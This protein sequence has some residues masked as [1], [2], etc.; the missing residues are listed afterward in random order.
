[1]V[2]TLK[3]ATCMQCHCNT[4]YMYII[5]TSCFSL[6]SFVSYVHCSVLC[7]TEDSISSEL[8]GTSH[9]VHHKRSFPLTTV[10]TCCVSYA[11]NR[12][13]YQQI[14]TTEEVCR[15]ENIMLLIMLFFHGTLCSIIV[16]LCFKFSFKNKQITV[17]GNGGQL[18]EEVEDNCWRKW[19][20]T[21][22]GSGGTNTTDRYC[23]CV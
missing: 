2:P 6:P 11:G 21:V 14:T 5:H 20:T 10:K 19:R 15:A 7:S 3:I 23:A 13:H 16:K 8:Q 12:V 22:G 17:R 18:L 4:Y 9:K 1:M